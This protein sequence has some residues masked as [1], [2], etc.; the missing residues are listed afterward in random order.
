MSGITFKKEISIANV[1]TIGA[2][3]VS[4]IFYIATQNTKVAVNTA[5]IA[6]NVTDVREIKTDI[7]D[8]RQDL[9]TLVKEN[10]KS[11]I[12]LRMA[13]QD[14]EVSRRAK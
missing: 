12:S 1:L 9:R 5:A 7:A 3:L 4:V 10:T 11:Q 6:S 2:A 8:I 13:I 14:L